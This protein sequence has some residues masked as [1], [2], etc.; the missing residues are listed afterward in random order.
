MDPGFD[1]RLVFMV[2]LALGCLCPHT[3]TGKTSRR[4]FTLRLQRSVRAVHR[5]KRPDASGA[6]NES[7]V[8]TDV[9]DVGCAQTHA[10]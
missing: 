3:R 6:Q 9:V 5:R 4:T 1:V 10:S 7:S 8:K 2:A